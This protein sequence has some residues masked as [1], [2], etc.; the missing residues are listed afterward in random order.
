VIGVAPASFFGREVGQQLDFALPICAV[1]SLTSDPRL[2]QL[3]HDG[4]QVLDDR[5]VLRPFPTA[6]ADA[7]ER[8]RRWKA[9]RRN[10][11]DYFSGC[12]I[13]I[14]PGMSAQDLDA[15]ANK[16]REK[17]E[18]EEVRCPQPERIVKRHQ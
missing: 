13:S 16:E 15:A 7:T 11:A 17:K 14:E 18:V 4:T 10:R 3:E 5:I 2:A 6:I 1:E 12:A 8:K 9:S